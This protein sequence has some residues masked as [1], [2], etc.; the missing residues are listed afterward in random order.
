MMGD[1]IYGAGRAPAIE[2]FI[3]RVWVTGRQNKPPEVTAGLKEA[4]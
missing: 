1:L 3:L 2:G 4:L